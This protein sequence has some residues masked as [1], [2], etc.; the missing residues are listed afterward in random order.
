M[1]RP[2]RTLELLM[3][4]SVVLCAV[5]SFQSGTPERVLVGILQL[6]V[7]CL[8]LLNRPLR[9]T[10]SPAQVASS[11]PS[12]AAGGIGVAIAAPW[13]DWN[14]ASTA[15]FTAGSLLAVVS[16]LTLGRSFGVLPAARKPVCTGVYRW[17]RHPAYVGQ[18]LMLAGCGI[19]SSPLL[20]LLI[21]LAC[22][23]LLALRI[24]AEERLL[25]ETWS[26]YRLYM[27]RVRWRICPL[28]W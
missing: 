12:L 10:A 9:R 27:Q 15:V 11:L 7:G 8:L 17:V 23:P 24:R 13:A 21:P 4:L 25:G 2:P 6:S 1:P 22:L 3:G 14:L 26:D 16:L 28:L 5:V 18:L 20:G 19:S